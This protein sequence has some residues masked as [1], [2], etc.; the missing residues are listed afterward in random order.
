MKKNRFFTALISAVLSLAMIFPLVGCGDNE[1]KLDDIF[2]YTVY[3]TYKVKRDEMPADKEILN[4]DALEITMVQGEYEI[5]QLIMNSKKDVN[6]YNATISDLVN[7]EN[8]NIVYKKENV[9]I[10]KQE[11][12]YI[13]S[14]GTKYTTAL[15]QGYTPGYYPDALIPMNA[16]INYGENHFKAGD[17]QGLTFQ[18]STRPELE[19]DIPVLK[20]G[21]TEEQAETMS[22]QE[23]YTY[24]PTGTYVGTITVDFKTFTKEIPVTLNISDAT[25]S[26]TVH[27]KSAFGSRTTKFNAELDYT[28]DAADLW[29]ASIIKYRHMTGRIW[30]EQQGSQASTD[31]KIAIARELLLR[32]RV[33]N[34]PWSMTNGNFENNFPEDEEWH[35]QWPELNGVACFATTN[36]MNQMDD[37]IQN[38]IKDDFNFFWKITIS[39]S[40]IDEPA[41]H[42]RFMETKASGVS[43]AKMLEEYSSYIE[44]ETGTDFRGNERSSF[45]TQYETLHPGKSWETFKADL[46]EAIRCLQMPVTQNWLEAYAP[47]VHCWCPTIPHYASAG[48][49]EDYANDYERWWYAW[50]HDVEGCL[51][52]ERAL[53]WMQAEYDVIGQLDWS[54]D[55]FYD[56][57]NDGKMID[58][59][60]TTMYLRS[61]YGNGDGYYF[62]PAAQYELDELIPSFRM[63]ARVDA[64]EEFE[65]F[66]NLKQIYAQIAKD[67]GLEIDPTGVISGLGANIYNGT[68]AVVDCGNFERTRRALINLSKCTESEARM[69]IVSVEDNGFG[70]MIYTIYLKANSDNTARTLKNNGQIVQPK[71]TMTGGGYL[72]EVVVDRTQSADNNIALEFEAG[73]ETM[74]YSQ[75]V[76]GKIS[77][78]EAQ[79]IGANSFLDGTAFVEAEL[80]GTIEKLEAEVGTHD[81]KI[82]IYGSQ[83]DADYVSIFVNSVKLNALFDSKVSQMV[84]HFYNPTNKVIKISALGELKNQV[85]WKSL[86][87]AELQPGYNSITINTK[88]NDWAKNPLLKMRW[89]FTNEDGSPMETDET[90]YLKDI[91]VYEL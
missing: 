64:F 47:Y 78:V 80:V 59:F 37:W 21:I 71:G 67:T 81:I 52:P 85:I 5:L 26:E 56:K 34:W 87:D 36:S 57:Y 23:K 49:R 13:G 4:A 17:N 22:D 51:V 33:N 18:F 61:S 44:N 41:S 16:V 19:N 74:I 6:W 42:N 89:T 54:I 2:F 50:V 90:I 15:W 12:M 48:Q 32:D 8:S 77:I 68:T 63:Q 14:I 25:V 70:K 62:Y 66:Y 46:V 82:D 40:I 38:C 24:N 73:G 11:Y 35:A 60:F 55:S 75:G 30:A 79:D 1:L 84:A 76:G 58:D 65:L 10:A 27:T 7:V 3:N 53:G 39:V 45:K 20:D 72:Y 43:L 29:N 86:F 83:A 28:Q 31:N 9:T 91:V 88:G 69:C